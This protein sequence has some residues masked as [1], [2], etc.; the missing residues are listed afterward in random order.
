MAGIQLAANRLTN[1]P[2]LVDVAVEETSRH[3]VLTRSL[4][5]GALQISPPLVI[6]QSDITYMVNQLE[7]ALNAVSASVESETIGR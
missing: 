1:D 6:T 2:P 4:V 3:G 7:D 5:G